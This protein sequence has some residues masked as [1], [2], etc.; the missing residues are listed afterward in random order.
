MT[1]IVR[2]YALQSARRVTGNPKLPEGSANMR[3]SEALANLSPCPESTLISL[4]KTPEKRCLSLRDCLAV[5]LRK[6]Q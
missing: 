4:L 5:A 3:R 2:S 6:T 1:A